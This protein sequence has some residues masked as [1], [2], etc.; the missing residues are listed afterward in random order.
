MDI[1]GQLLIAMPGMGDPRFARSVIFMCAHS[2]EGAMGLMLNKRAG[3]MTLREVFSRLDIAGAK[4]AGRTP[5]H[6]GG[7]VETER[8]FVLHGD[9]RRLAP[10][11]LA[12]DGQ[13]VLTATQ[14]I[15]KD[16]GN[17][18]GPLP[19]FFAL[20]YA[21]WSAGQ[22][23]GEIAQNGWLTAPATPDLVFATSHDALWDAALR[24]IG[25]DPVT[26][27]ATAGRA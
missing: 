10:D 3:D 27:S 5:V 15:L 12:I 23:E 19:F 8:G 9:K 24:S 18:K 11:A 14:D 6:I 4:D 25:I 20:G 13:Y 26:L 2:D 22:L 7:P 21:G 17:G 16:I 1:S